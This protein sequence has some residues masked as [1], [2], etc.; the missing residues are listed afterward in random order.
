MVL[1]TEKVALAA[2]P[3]ALRSALPTPAIAISPVASL[4]TAVVVLIA[5]VDKAVELP[6]KLL[7]SMSPA[8]D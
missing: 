7:I 4:P 1:P 2:V 8:P 3:A 6:I 5:T